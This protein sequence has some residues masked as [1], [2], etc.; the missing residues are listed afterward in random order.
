MPWTWR[1][2]TREFYPAR[3]LKKYPV[4]FLN[5]GHSFPPFCP[6]FMWCW[7]FNEAHGVHYG[8]NETFVPHT[9]GHIMLDI[10]GCALEN[11]LPIADEKEVEQ[12][13]ERRREWITRTFAPRWDEMWR[14]QEEEMQA[15]FEK[16]KAFDFEKASVY[17]LYKLLHEAVALNRRM[18]EWHFYFMYGQ[19]GAYWEFED[20]ARE[21]AGVVE[22][23]A[24][25]H[26]LIR[27]FDNYLFR[28]DRALWALRTRALELKIDD[29]LCRTPAAETLAALKETAAGQRWV[30]EDLHDFLHLKGYGWRQPRMM[31]FINPLWWEDPSPVFKWVKAYLNLDLGPEA[32]FPLEA[33]RPRLIERRRAAEAEVLRRAR[34]NGCPD[35][36]Y[37]EL[38]M[39]L[40]QKT[41]FYSESHDWIN[42]IQ[43]HAVNRHV[44]RKIG[45]RLSEFGTFDEPDDVFFFIPE[46]LELFVG[47]PEN[48]E[49]GWLAR[50]RRREWQKHTAYENRPAIESA[51]KNLRPEDTL[52]H[53]LGPR[54][55]VVTKVSIGPFVKPR[56][57][58]GA[59]CFG[60]CGNVGLAEGVARRVVSS[61]EIYDVKP[62][63]ILVAPATHGSW[64]PVWPMVKAVVT[65]GGGSVSHACIVG[66]EWDVPVVANT[67]DATQVIKTG[68]RLR[69]DSEAGL[70]F[71][72]D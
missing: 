17:D 24:L 57:E 25:W 65:D 12:R 27:G 28:M 47:Y 62:G 54:D 29:L 13:L 6:L 49:V 55:P 43:C 31:E 9:R 19:F 46:E 40:A 42:E 37:F 33:I 8:C 63:E 52:K 56:P 5:K 30:E 50:E 53:L 70:V 60:N 44:F 14:S 71:R 7:C 66:R 22:T 68:D 15:A 48:F 51:D 36:A 11:G 67:G 72:L 2:H 18:W 21:Y 26:D 45:Q 16:H 64:T 38:M 3:D 34:K 58:T 59:V 1:L 4:W 69:V 39:G 10:D 32:E 35:M 23:D 41:S 20:L 61:A